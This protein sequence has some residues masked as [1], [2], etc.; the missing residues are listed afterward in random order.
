[1]LLIFL[2]D[3]GK[4]KKL[5]HIYL[6]GLSFIKYVATQTY[7]SCTP[8]IYHWKLDFSGSCPPLQIPVGDG[9]G[10]ANAFC[11]V[12]GSSSDDLIPVSV[13]AYTII[14]LD[15]ELTP[16]KIQSEKDVNLVDGSLIRF[17][18]LTAAEPNIYTGGLQVEISAVNSIDEPIR[19]VWILAFSNS[20]EILPFLS[21]DLLGWLSY[22]SKVVKLYYLASITTTS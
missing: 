10:I 2:S 3:Y 17:S 11:K 14:E 16:L 15:D 9:Y 8:L 4:M 5:L 12:T 6:L 20:C 18:S 19:L 13:T 1:M 7:C 22:V 21:G